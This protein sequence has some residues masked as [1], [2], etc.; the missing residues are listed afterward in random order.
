M[1]QLKIPPP[2]YAISI[3]IIMWLLSKYIP[4]VELI[5][6][7][8]N[9]IGLGIIIIAACFDVW[10]L[11]LFLKKHTTPNPMKPENTTGIVTKGL[12][13]YSRNPM[14]LGLLI[15]LF[16]FGIWLGSLSPFLMLPMFYWLITEMQIKPEERMLEQKFGKEYLDFKNRVRRWL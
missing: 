3:A 7:P 2:V 15:I 14:Y 16:G 8:W 13:Q 5:Q 9:K 4:I 10:S 12:Y 6:S 1:L 11:F